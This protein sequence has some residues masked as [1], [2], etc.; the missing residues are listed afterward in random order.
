MDPKLDL[1]DCIHTLQHEEKL[2]PQL[3]GKVL[4]ALSVK[5]QGHLL[6]HVE[7]CILLYNDRFLNTRAVDI[8]HVLQLELVIKPWVA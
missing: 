4:G 5:P 2:T 6:Q 7:E 1:I 3:E 8:G